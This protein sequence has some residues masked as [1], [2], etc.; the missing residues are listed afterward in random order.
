MLTFF[1]RANS[2][3]V[4]LH[5][6][7]NL[8]ATHNT[9]QHTQIHLEVFTQIYLHMMTRA[10]DSCNASYET[11]SAEHLSEFV[12]PKACTTRITTLQL[13]CNTVYCHRSVLATL[14]R[15]TRFSSRNWEALD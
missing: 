3:L 12:L 5:I 13:Q 6:P 15:D 9:Q 2:Q 11:F 7:D 14:K 8:H 1:L 4:S 10:H